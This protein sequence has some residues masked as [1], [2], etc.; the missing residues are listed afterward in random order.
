MSGKLPCCLFK[1]L[2]GAVVFALFSAC[3][4]DSSSSNN[5]EKLSDADVEVDSYR[6]LSTCNGKHE[7]ETAYVVDQD[8]AY[9]CKD[10]KWVE[11]DDA[12]EIKSSSSSTKSSSS[13]EKDDQESSSSSVSDLEEDLSSSNV[14]SS[15]SES[16]VSSSSMSFGIVTRSSSS[17]L[18]TPS[19]SS[20]L[21]VLEEPIGTCVP[22][23]ET[24]RINE[25]VKWGFS[26]KKEITKILPAMT[27]VRASY[28][29]ILEGEEGFAHVTTQGKKDVTVAYSKSGVKTAS[30]S[31]EF[32][33]YEKQVIV[34]PEVNVTG[35]EFVNDGDT[36][37][38]I[39]LSF[40][41]SSTRDEELS[42][43]SDTPS[44]SSEIPDPVDPSTVTTGTMTDSRDGQTY[45]TV[46][47][48]KQT[49]MAENLNYEMENSSCYDNVADNCTKSGRLYTWDAA[50]TA[51][52]S[53]W[54]LPAESEW[55]ELIY[56][57]GGE[58]TAG[59][60]LKSTSGW[61]GDEARFVDNAPFDCKKPNGVDAYSFTVLPLDEDGWY[62][63]FW[64]STEYDDNEFLDRQILIVYFAGSSGN[65][66]D[67]CED[68]VY[69]S[70]TFGE[71]ILSIRCVKD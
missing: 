4:D 40:S 7:G 21:L 46:T 56:S 29:W 28:E 63:E 23:L 69:L 70:R 39:R 41:S 22:S 49:W 27:L 57:V 12:V 58:A 3:G 71:R 62:A 26:F 14:A 31:I 55:M 60:M 68:G 64:S 1:A 5:Q 19:S 65:S 9:I 33:G 10:G 6:G 18:E 37:D 34:C 67:C 38:V 66:S 11:D 45:K 30:V 52:P 24:A 20:E 48:G 36:S 2:L 15:S 13:S 44:S 59:K 54:H 32:P 53:G 42:S 17:M 25:P 16:I 47:I 50:T 61:K 51:C 43:S 35:E 8:Q